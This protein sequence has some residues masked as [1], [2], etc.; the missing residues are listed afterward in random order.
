MDQH[1]KDNL[2]KALG[3]F[4]EEFRAYVVERL[5]KEAGEE[6]WSQWFM[7]SLSNQQLHNWQQAQLNG[8]P[9]ETLIDFQHLKG[10][11]IKYKDLVKADFGR[12]VNNLPTWLS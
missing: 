10:F 3:L 4:I 5:T 12:K 2:Y 1:A 6:K 9:P 7:E 8:T 11:A